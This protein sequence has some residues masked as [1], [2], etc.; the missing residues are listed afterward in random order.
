VYTS[1]KL[2]FGKV[3]LF[4]ASTCFYEEDGISR[5]LAEASELFVVFQTYYTKW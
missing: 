1:V 2:Q 5:G 4:C 3:L